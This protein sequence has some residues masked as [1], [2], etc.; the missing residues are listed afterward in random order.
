[1][2]DMT[3]NNHHRRDGMG[4]VVI[5]GDYQGLG[6]VRSLG[7]Q[8]IPVCVIDD[9]RSI[10]RY[11]RYTTVAQRVPSLLQ[12]KDTVAALLEFGRACKLRGWVL[13]PT[14][15]EQVAAL[16]QNH[17]ELSE[18]FRVPTP[19]WATVKWL[20]DKRNTYSLA[21][22]LGI[23]TPRT[24]YPRR[25]ED[26][27]QIEGHYPVA[28]KPA[29]KEHFIYAT[30]DK[31]WRADTPTQLR[32]LFERALRIIP[33]EE[34]MIQDLIPGD[35]TSQ[36]AYCS[37]FRQ[38]K[39]IAHLTACRRRQHPIEFGRSST[40][41]ETIESPLLEEYSERFLRTID[42]YGLVE[43]EYKRD[44]RDGQYRLLDVNGRTWGYH[45]IGRK[46]GIDFPYLLFADQM[47]EPVEPCKGKAGVRWIRLLTD[48]PTGVLEVVKGKTEGR[49]YL[50]SL[51][52]YDE[53]A[54]FSLEDPLPGMVEVALIP[55]LAMK[56]GY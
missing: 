30:K 32:E 13:Y 36:Y 31:A 42:Y 47:N 51:M 7:R 15:D 9:E 43:V 40:Y 24:W 28:I 48:F 39:S 55:Y 49:A 45:T 6:I 27:A 35:G 23:P 33:A 53:E 20:W 38:G 1:M 34:I 3:S 17:D 2:N 8:D 25:L 26:L 50:Q 22:K 5:G 44:L 18:V 12:P 19:L 14:R 29:I 10:A 37:F 11:S 46:A 4:A 54:V 16:S 56:R 41:V 21:E 52:D